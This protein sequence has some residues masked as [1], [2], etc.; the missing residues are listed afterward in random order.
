MAQSSITD[1]TTSDI[2]RQLTV[3][4]AT[5][6]LTLPVVA[7]EVFS[8]VV[9]PFVYGAL[10]IFVVLFL[11]PFR[12]VWIAAERSSPGLSALRILLI[13]AAVADLM[14]PGFRTVEV[15]SLRWILMTFVAVLSLL[16]L[17]VDIRKAL[18]SH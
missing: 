7:R 2:G 18:S 8:T 15:L 17:A 12:N 6:A 11:I 16:V 3:D 1:N 10:L 4:V 13:C 9:V 5:M 14:L